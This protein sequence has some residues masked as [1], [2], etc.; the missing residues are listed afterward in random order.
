MSI[1]AGRLNKRITISQKNVTRDAYGGES[2][3]WEAFCTV[4]AAVL[5]IRG[6]EYVAIRDAGA[7]LTTRF[8]I[9]YRSGITPAMRIEYGGAMY[10]IIDVINPQEART[11]MEIMARAEA[12][13]S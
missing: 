8:L 6:R 3:Q 2:I 12:V 5:P 10:D 4:W 11:H 7:E 9:R 1:E 13:A